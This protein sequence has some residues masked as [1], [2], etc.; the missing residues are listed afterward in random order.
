[1][2]I[3]EIKR[4]FSFAVIIV[5]AGL[6]LYSCKKNEIKRGGT[7]SF[8]V[9]NAIVGGNAVIL[10]QSPLD[11]VVNKSSK[12]L[13]ATAGDGLYISVFAYGKAGRMYYGTA[14]NTSD[15]D[16]YTLL[17]SGPADGT[18]DVLAFRETAIPSANANSISV[19]FINLVQDGPAVSLNLVGEAPGPA[20]AYKGVGQFK[21]YP[22]MAIPPVTY[23]F[24]IRDA[25]TGAVLGSYSLNPSEAKVCTLVW[26]GKIGGEGKLAPGILRVNHYPQ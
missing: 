19:R 21:N 5:M 13:K 24:E 18:P 14:L 7:V 26:N 22:E 9:V 3:T 8:N 1:M 12:L 11:S 6:S 16:V 20:L 17:L 2:N 23:D 4:K 25:S 15:G 10:N